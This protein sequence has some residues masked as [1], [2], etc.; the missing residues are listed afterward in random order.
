MN[1]YPD[2]FA[3]VQIHGGD[4]GYD[5]PWGDARAD[6]Y[7]LT[8]FPTSYY[9]G[10]IARIGAWDYDTYHDDYI[11]RYAVPTSVTINLTGVRVIGQTYDIRARVCMES[12]GSTESMRIYMV[13][14]LDYW[15]P[16]VSYSRNGFKQ[17]ASTTDIRSS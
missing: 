4:D 2:T 10:V 1:T 13:Q 15:P 3:F 7:G 17:A 6:F 12:D 14:V 5:T 8:G 9:D 11:A 16:V